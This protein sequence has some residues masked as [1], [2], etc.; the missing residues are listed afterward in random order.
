MTRPENAAAC[1]W[2]RWIASLY[3]WKSS[4]YWIPA[5]CGRA[6]GPRRHGRWRPGH[7]RTRRPDP[8][9]R[10]RTTRSSRDPD[11][12]TGTFTALDDS[13]VTRVRLRW[14]SPGATVPLSAP[15]PTTIKPT[16]RDPCDFLS[17]THRLLVGG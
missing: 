3:D 5:S 12:D 16:N 1:G 15:Q 7:P 11:A 9:R 2:Q 8:G 13:K 14:L 6:G 17:L 4:A 10:G